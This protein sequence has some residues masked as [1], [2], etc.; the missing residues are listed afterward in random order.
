MTS[1][2]FPEWLADP[3]RK[4]L[5]MGVLNIT[6]DSFSDGARFLATSEDASTT[7]EAVLT[8][9]IAAEVQAMTA[10]GVDWIDVGGEST[11]PGSSPVPPAV[12]IK[13]V[14]PAIQTIRQHSGVLISV[15][16]SR[17]EVA[18]AA[19]DAGADVVNDIWAGRDDAEMLPLVARR[20][21]PIILMHMLG[22]PATMQANPIYQDVTA[23]VAEFF[24]KRVAAAVAAGVDPGL[25]LL[26]PGI[27]F[28]KTAAHNLQLLRQT[29]VLCRIGRPLVVG[30][31]RKGFIGKV[32]DETDPQKRIFG[33]AATV[34]YAVANG[35]AVVRVHDVGPMRQVVRMVRAIQNGSSEGY[36]HD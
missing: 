1:A 15:D 21:T 17:A 28:G 35:A 8:D 16:T 13:R 22:S 6:P 33:T 24:G 2:E 12:Q 31:S 11:R 20:K 29:A 18:T 27:G 19:L 26:D 14:V 34:A 4:P 5:V 9:A 23:D 3:R 25:I 10:A 30:T 36:S 7:A 32:L